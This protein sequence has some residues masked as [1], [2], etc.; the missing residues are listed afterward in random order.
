MAKDYTS[1]AIKWQ[2]MLERLKSGQVTKYTKEIKKLE[3]LVRVTIAEAGEDVAGLSIR[4][5]NKLIAKLNAGQA[6]IY[7]VANSNLAKDSAGIAN[8]YA[9]QEVIALTR[10]V[11]LRGT[12]L[13]KFTKKQTFARVLKRPLS[14]NGALLEPW[15]RDFTVTEIARVSNTIRMGHAQGKTNREMVQQ[16]IGTRAGSFQDGILQTTRRN[17]S[18]VVRTS[19]Q[20]VASAVRNDVWVKNKDVVKG[21]EWLSTLDSVTS[22][23]CQ[24]L[25]GQEFELGKGPVPPIHPNCRSTTTAVLDSKFDFLDEGATRSAKGGPVDADTT[26][27]GWLNDQDEKT[28]VDVLGAKRAKLFQDGGLSEEKFRALQFDKNF[29]PLN[30]EEMRKI[31]PAAFKKAGI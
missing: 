3:R 27:F 4:E 20:H 25:D 18:T 9:A 15:I 29:A 28:Q 30:L 11:D 2:V 16:V 22:K 7:G 13:D 1:L 12:K 10:T 23:Q 8:V 17:A 26:Y 21:Y 31:E 14:T 5:L 19:V 6:E 24:S